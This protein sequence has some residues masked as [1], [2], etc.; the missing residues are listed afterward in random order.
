M[1]DQHAIVSARWCGP[2]KVWVATSGDIPGLMVIAPDK[3]DLVHEVRLCVPDLLPADGSAAE[4]GR[5]VIQYYDQDEI[6]PRAA[7][8]QTASSRASLSGR[9]LDRGAAPAGARVV[10][11]VGAD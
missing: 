11:T 4:R 7:E 5:I 3:Q 10:E 2:S 6:W 9:A 8:T 1:A